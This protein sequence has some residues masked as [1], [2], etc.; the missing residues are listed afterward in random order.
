MKQ[1]APEWL[2]LF[3]EYESWCKE[4][5]FVKQIDKLDMG[6][7]AILYQKTNRAWTCRISC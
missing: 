3:E 4:A 1:L 7:Q 5:R 2:E 6:L